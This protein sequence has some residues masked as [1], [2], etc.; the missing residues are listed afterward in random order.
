MSSGAH[1]KS[2]FTRTVQQYMGVSWFSTVD[3]VGSGI[4]SPA[5]FTTRGIWLRRLFPMMG[6]YINDRRKLSLIT[7]SISS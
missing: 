2:L 5:R 6:W 4:P 7:F 1:V 3:A